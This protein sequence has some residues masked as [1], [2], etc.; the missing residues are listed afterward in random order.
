MREVEQTD[1]QLLKVKILVHSL[2]TLP[3]VLASFEQRH[4]KQTLNNRAHW[5]NTD[6]SKSAHTH[7]Q[8]VCQIV[9]VKSSIFCQEG[10]RLL[11]TEEFC[12]YYSSFHQDNQ[13]K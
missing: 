11:T 13:L 5:L 10:S 4:E 3:G 7:H 12:L 6:R 2:Q 1:L 8:V 9:V